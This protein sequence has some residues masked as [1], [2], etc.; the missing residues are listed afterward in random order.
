MNKAAE[1]LK[2]RKKMEVR[3]IITGEELGVMKAALKAYA[4]TA[5]KRT[6]RMAE[7]MLWLI[8]YQENK[9]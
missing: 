6:K 4:E 7:D 2:Q 9:N 1:K 3:I 5:T 8:E